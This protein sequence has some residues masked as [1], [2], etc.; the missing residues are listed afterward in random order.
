MSYSRVDISTEYSPTWNCPFHG[1]LSE[2]QMFSR[3]PIAP[4]PALSSLFLRNDRRRPRF[5]CGVTLWAKLNPIVGSAQS[6]GTFSRIAARLEL[7]S[8][9]LYL[10]TYSKTAASA[11]CTVSDEYLSFS[12][13]DGESRPGASLFFRLSLYPG[14]KG[15][16]ATIAHR[17]LRRPV[18]LRK[19]VG[20][21]GPP[22]NL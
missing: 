22:T 13:A 15:W 16:A 11:T 14:A 10:G 12:R 18:V 3:D 6:L 21:V 2:Y 8:S 20:G 5:T 17:R 9:T 1:A 4:R 19:F 7:I